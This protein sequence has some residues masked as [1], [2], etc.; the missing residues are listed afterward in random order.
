[1]NTFRNGDPIPEAKSE[2]EWEKAGREQQPAWCYYDNDAAKGKKYGRLYNWYAVNDPRGLAPEGW[3]I[4]SDGEWK[5]LTDSLG[6]E[7][8]RSMKSAGGWKENGNGNNRCGF[9][10]LPGGYRYE[11]GKFENLETKSYW[12]SSTD[13]LTYV[14][15]LRSISF[16]TADVYR[17]FSTKRLGLSVR[18]IKD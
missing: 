3:H 18:C 6:P 16:F 7:A 1:V 5:T 10:A 15:F 12:W 4:P 14:A 8:G 11:N 9:K 2:T 17:S 13:L